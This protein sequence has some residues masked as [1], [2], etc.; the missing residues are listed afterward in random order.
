M[1]WA[2]ARACTRSLQ[3]VTGS[4]VTRIIIDKANGKPQALGVEFSLSGPDGVRRTAELAPGGEV[5]LAAGAVHSPHILQLSGVGPRA[6]LAE[7]GVPLVADLPAVG[8]N[9]QDQPA[10]LAA[11]PAKAKY[12]GI[13]LSDHIYSP[14]G[15]LRKR[16]IAAFLLLGRGPLTSTGCDHGGFFRTAGQAGRVGW[17]SG[18]T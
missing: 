3:V 4:K 1:A 13:S 9:L 18:R 2:R 16:A 12:D 11:V 17:D 5:I 8:Q 14:K 6:A 15:K 7:A 10:V